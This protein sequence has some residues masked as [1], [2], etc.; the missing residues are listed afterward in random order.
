MPEYSLKLL[1]LCQQTVA[2]TEEICWDAA[3]RC[4]N[5]SVRSKCHGER[6]CV[7]GRAGTLTVCFCAAAQPVCIMWGLGGR[8]GA[9]DGVHGIFCLH[10]LTQTGSR[11]QEFCIWNRNVGTAGVGPAAVWCAELG[12]RLPFVTEVR[13]EKAFCL[14]GGNNRRYHQM[15]QDS[16]PIS[17]CQARMWYI[18]WMM[19]ETS[20]SDLDISA[21][22]SFSFPTSANNHSLASS[23]RTGR[24]REWIS[25]IIHQHIHSRETNVR[26]GSILKEFKALAQ[27]DR[28]KTDGGLH[29]V[30]LVLICGG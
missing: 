23:F 20:I 9:H 27:K 17:Q 1:S 7:C 5:I 26:R 21:W 11:R 10:W 6:C 29:E 28:R 12:C 18:C 30:W 14:S 8:S 13:C 16:K 25:A 4:Y 22:P 2:S 15:M 3:G 24:G 19:I